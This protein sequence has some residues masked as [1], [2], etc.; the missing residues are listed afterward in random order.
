MGVCGS[1]LLM[2]VLLCGLF[3]MPA[4]AQTLLN[5]SGKK[6]KI[7]LGTSFAYDDNVVNTPNLA[8]ARPAGLPTDSGDTSFS[9]NVQS[10]LKH[11][12]SNKFFVRAS[13]DIDMTVYSDLNQYDLTTQI[14]GMSPTYKITPTMQLMMDY[15]FI[16]NIVNGA[17]FS[18]INYIGPSFNHMHP[19]FGL[20]RLYYTFKTTHNWQNKLRHNQHHT[21]GAAHFFFFSNYTRRIGIDYQ[22]S[23]ENTQGSAFDRDNH[24]V[25]IK[26][27]TP[28]LWGWQGE[29][30]IAY[31]FRNYDTRLANLTALRDDTLQ[32]YQFGVSRVLI[33]QWSYLKNLTLT[34]KYRRLENDSNLLPRDFASNRGDISLLARF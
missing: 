13:Y 27:A 6:W 34:L 20:S 1:V 11:S 9:L 15:N 26:G 22:Y 18:G 28:L 17:N 7:N 4:N 23:T 19:K 10:S 8:T 21:V 2:G 12:F 32:R 24:R 25:K 14:F 5:E 33:E 29:I 3:Q 16:Y 31:T 30:D